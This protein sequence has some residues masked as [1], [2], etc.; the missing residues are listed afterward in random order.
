MEGLAV[1][2]ETWGECFGVVEKEP[3]ELK[4]AQEQFCKSE[5][6]RLE[7]GVACDKLRIELALANG[8]IQRLEGIATGRQY[9]IE[10][11]QDQEAELKG[12]KVLLRMLG[13]HVMRV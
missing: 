6:T 10:R 13:K 11:L 5:T 9:E 1:A 8:E 4:R 12:V 2:S 3:S 7:L